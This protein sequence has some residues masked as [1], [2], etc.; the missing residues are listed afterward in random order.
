[1]EQVRLHGDEERQRVRADKDHEIARLSAEIDQLKSDNKALLE[2]LR[3]RKD[4]QK[5]E[6]DVFQRLGQGQCR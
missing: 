3:G 4:H 6:K 5:G 2:E 1:M